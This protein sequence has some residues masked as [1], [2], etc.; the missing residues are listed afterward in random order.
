M[1]DFAD[2]LFAGNIVL[3]YFLA[4]TILLVTIFTS[5]YFFR[6]KFRYSTT[7]IATNETVAKSFGINVSRTILVVFTISSFFPGFIGA[8]YAHYI[9]FINPHIGFDVAITLAVLT[10][11][12]FGGMGTT[13]G[14]IIGATI[15]KFIEEILR[16]N[17]VYGHMIV[18][19]IILVVVI[20]YLPK[21]LLGFLSKSFIGN[22]N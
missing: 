11:T 19:G 6:S 22:R 20:L 13:F 2:A 1:W 18:Y 7:A 12:I 9:A 15:L 21:G 3:C 17:F 10:M 14:P 5:I 8:Y 16:T 4:F